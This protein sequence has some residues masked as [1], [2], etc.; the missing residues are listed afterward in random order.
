MKKKKTVV[1]SIVAVLILSMLG[2][3]FIEYK[4][5]RDHK[6]AVIAEEAMIA[7]Q[8][9]SER[10]AEEKRVKA[11]EIAAA[12]KKSKKISDSLD[13]KLKEMGWDREYLSFGQQKD[14]SPIYLSIKNRDYEMIKILIN[15]NARL[16]YFL[17]N[18]RFDPVPSGL[19]E[20]IKNDDFAMVEFL[21]DNGFPFDVGNEYPKVL[22]DINY[23]ENIDMI[24]LLLEK[25]YDINTPR[26]IQRDKSIRYKWPRVLGLD[27]EIVQLFLDNGL[28][29]NAI[30]SYQPQGLR[31]II[32]SIPMEWKLSE[33]IEALLIENGAKEFSEFTVEDYKNIKYGLLR[34]VGNSTSVYSTF[35]FGDDSAVGQI[36]IDEEVYLLYGGE[37]EKCFIKFKGDKFGWISRS[38][39]KEIDSR[40]KFELLGSR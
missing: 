6:L 39:L 19:A 24:K 18:D 31:Y 37:D 7:K 33:D 14:E 12:K 25:G 10:I 27:I 16:S 3:Y 35:E 1:W 23:T 13:R 15:E 5:A 30:F 29:V 8:V 2:Y 40:V 36:D 32:S 28:D 11:E 20:P 38:N 17:S 26:I 21:L 9:E 34:T 22:Y 4:P